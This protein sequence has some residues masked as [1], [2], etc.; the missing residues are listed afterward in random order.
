MYRIFSECLTLTLGALHSIRLN[1][2]SF[3]IC[4][5]VNVSEHGSG[6]VISGTGDSKDMNPGCS[7]NNLHDPQR[8]DTCVSNK[9][10]CCAAII[11]R[12]AEFVL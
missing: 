11:S 9:S 10:I 4:S 3:R 7:L 6:E 5:P 2:I 12:R 1:R 8:V